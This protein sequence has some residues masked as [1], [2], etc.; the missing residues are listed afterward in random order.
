MREKLQQKLRRGIG[1]ALCMLLCMVAGTM[2]MPEI[3]KADTSGYLDGNGVHVYRDTPGDTE[4]AKYQVSVNGTA[5][6]AIK[7]DK[8]GNNFDIARFATGTMNPSITVTLPNEEIN[9]VKVYPER[10]Y[11]EESLQVSVDKHTLTFQMSADSNLR[12]VYV[13]INGGPA[14]QAGKPY[15]A[16][17]NDPVESKPDLSGKNVLNF[18]TFS[19]QYL[20]S[21]PNSEAEKAEEAGVTSGGVSY[22]AGQ[23]VDNNTA[24]VRFPNKR[25]ML[26][27]DVTYAL[28]AA[29]DEIYKDGSSYDTLYFPDG[30]YICSGLEIKDRNGKHVNIYLDEGALV[31][32]RLQE[33]MQAMEPAIGIWDSSDITIS[34]RGMFDGNGV[35]NY[36]KDRHDAKDSCHQGGVMIMRSSNIVFNDT[37][38]R[39]A[40]QWNWESHGSKNCT[41]NNIKGLTPY[42]QPWVDGLDM[43][44]AQD[45]TINGALTMGN[46]DNFASGHYNP[47]D[48]FTNTVP[49]FDQYNSEA[50]SWDTEDSFNV[51]VSNTLGWSYAGGNGIR[52]GHNTYG[53]QMKN[54]T[55][56]NVNTSNFRG[57]GRGITV[58][59][60]TGTYPRYESIII[61]NSSFDTTRVGTNMDIN[62][63]TDNMIDTVT[64]ENCWFSNGNIDNKCNNIKN[65][66]ITNLYMGGKRVTVSTFARVKTSNVTNFVYDWA[67]NHEP[68]FT[69]PSE[70][71]YNA[72]VGEKVEIKVEATDED[73][74]EVTL[75]A[76]GLPEG[77]AF[78][79]GTFTWTPGD[80]Q[81]GTAKVVFAAT[82]AK[83]AKVT[84]EITI[85][86]KDK[87]GNTAPVLA[88]PDGAP[89]TVKV[90]ENLT[91]TVTATDEQNDTFTISAT[92]LPRGAAFDAES[93]S[94]SWT[95]GASQTGETKVT[96]TATDC[97]G[98]SSTLEVQITVDAG[99]YQTVDVSATEDVYLASWKD[100]KNKNYEDNEYLRVRRMAG[101]ASD[102]GKYGLFGEKI[103][104]TSDSN[105]AKISV[106]KFDATELKA[107][108]KNLEKAELELT[109][110][111]RRDNSSTGT[112]RLMITAVTS[113][114]ESTKVTWNTHPNWNSDVRYSDEFHVDKNGAVKNQTGIKAS[115]Y[116]GTKVTV[117]VT[118]LVKNLSDTDDVLSLAVCEEK[119]YELAFAST[120]GAA[121]LGEDKAAAPVLRLS[122]KKQEAQETEQGKVTVSEDTFAG[123]WSSDQTKNYGGENFLRTSYSNNSTGVLGT[124]G[125]TDNKVTYLKFDI[126]SIDLTKTDKVKLRMTLLGIRYAEGKNLDAQI[127]VGMATDNSWTESGLTWKNKPEVVT[128]ETDL[129]A[130]EVFNQGEVVN[131]EPRNISTPV[132]TT[133]TADV[134]DFIAAAKDAEKDIITLVVNIDGS[135][136]KDTQDKANRIYFVSKEGAQNYANASDM[137]PTLVSIKCEEAEH[138]HSLQ[139]VEEKAATC[140]E[141]GNI[142]YYVCKTCG[143]LF[144]DEEGTT[145][146]T[147]EETEV[148][149]AHTIVAHEKKA[150]TCTEDGNDAYYA[151]DKCGKMFTDETATEEIETVPVTKAT[152]HSWGDGVVTVEPTDD[153]EGVRTYTCGNCGD[154]MTEV[155]PKTDSSAEEVNRIIAGADAFVGSGTDDQTKNYGSLNFLCTSYSSNSTGVLGTESGT[156]NKVTYLKF[157]ISSI[158]L[159]Q[160]D[161]VKLQMTLLGVQDAVDG[162]AKLQVGMAGNDW[163]EGEITWENKPAV[164]TAAADLAESETFKLGSVVSNDPANITIPEG[165]V[166][167]VDVTNFVA[168]A[169]TAGNT[170]LTL[171]VNVDGSNG[172]DNVNRIFFVSREGAQV[173]PN[174][175]TQAPTL[176][177][178]KYKHVHN[179]VKTDAKA[180]TCT[181]DGNIEYYTCDGCGKLYK[182]A[183]GEEEIT[184]LETVLKAE[185]HKWNEGEI[186]TE[187]TEDTEGVKTYTCEVCKE[188]KTETLPKLGHTL[189]KHEAKEATCTE[190]GT[191]E[192]YECTGCGKLF[193]DSAGA[194]EITAEET[195]EK[196]KGHQWDEGVVTKEATKKEE[197]EK[198][199]TCQICKE[200][201]TEVIPKLPADPKKDPDPTPTVTPS[202]TPEATPTVTPSETPSPTQNP[203]QTSNPTTGKTGTTGN[204]TTSRTATSGNNTTTAAKTGDHTQV[205]LWLLILLA[206]AGTI[207]GCIYKTRKKAK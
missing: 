144:S 94:F 12:Y 98:A 124:A 31:K 141:D 113:A 10:Y 5:V 176:L 202:A 48:G 100:E 195:I 159:K 127:L 151:C 192:Y 75:S 147:Q 179:L 158:D 82:D 131:N 180:A 19:E 177:G 183:A 204:T 198:T 130:S 171:V 42:N 116:D 178:V 57:G 120:E 181:E 153:A 194:V 40:K 119:G 149:A 11:P 126:S 64:V 8:N 28:Q 164:S 165:T 108:L 166:A 74:E 157:D 85:H 107:N 6:K 102:E 52:M 88:T 173:Y 207:C 13:M 137:A 2:M 63:K 197:G 142:T 36:S 47:S 29:L 30:T 114:W 92:D 175:A 86:V 155:I 69:A 160:V 170:E 122:V 143:K 37:Y 34:G 132:G 135:R 49:G 22:D 20:A 23:L 174:G 97:W 111:N 109:L 21:H 199:Y 76:D 187:P 185:G 60:S 43:A 35:A 77:A 54:Y 81:L 201:K 61:K 148:K 89:Y 58:Q 106:L 91:F 33:C 39:D 168:A 46:D 83:G 1:A 73:E 95:P 152:G 18:Q 193:R 96:F 72:K 125:G 169:K 105:D 139:K 123:S 200:T 134:T 191:S 112:D 4:S 167:T 186:T 184:L 140:T 203:G 56:D 32:N 45:L 118:D 136:N 55:F 67:D 129:V 182:D 190:D 138:V 27:N 110:I 172:I 150:A 71:S 68:E 163:T 78:A 50:L 99:M 121:K 15:L 90:G 162:Q 156:D 17:I 38:V 117:D 154:T 84:K 206:A 66:T 62:G 133:V 93:G 9:T 104:S 53:H 205:A 25:K 145:E 3:A 189:K 128:S 146:I 103:T 80:D 16:L 26:D 65:L 14:D 196:A 51:N 24:Q 44:S 101:A 79:D 41:L 70:T 188:T 115:T 59:N 161:K 87:V 7:Y